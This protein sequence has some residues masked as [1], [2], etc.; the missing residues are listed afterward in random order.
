MKEENEGVPAW[1]YL[2]GGLAAG[3]TLGVLFAPKKGSELRGAIKDWTDARTQEGK[4]FLARVKKE[5]PIAVERAKE[6]AEE[7]IAAVKERVHLV[8]G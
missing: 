4:A 6:R 8:K 2:L 1:A 3:V 7:A 5:T